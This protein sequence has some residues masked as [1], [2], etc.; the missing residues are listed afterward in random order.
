MAD[1][2]PAYFF[3]SFL[4]EAWG[5][6]EENWRHEIKTACKFGNLNAFIFLAGKTKIPLTE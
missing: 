4:E 5:Y 3:Y 2:L 6:G 1:C